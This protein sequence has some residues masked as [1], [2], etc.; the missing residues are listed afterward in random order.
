MKQRQILN[1]E[2]AQACLRQ[3]DAQVESYTSLY[4][5]NP[6]LATLVSY[7]T[8]RNMLIAAKENPEQVLNP[9]WI[10]ENGLSILDSLV[11]IPPSNWR[12]VGN[13]PA[14]KWTKVAN[15][16]GSKKVNLHKQRLLNPKYL[17]ELHQLMQAEESF[18]S[19]Y[20]QTFA[21][22]GV[23]YRTA[24][25]YYIIYTAN[26]EQ[27][28]PNWALE[29]GRSTEEAWLLPPENIVYK[30]TWPFG[31]WIN[32]SEMDLTE[33]E[34]QYLQ[35]KKRKRAKTPKPYVS[36]RQRLFNPHLLKRILE[37]LENGY[38][39]TDVYESTTALHGQ[40]SYSSLWRLIKQDYE[41]NPDAVMPSWAL[42]MQDVDQEQVWL[43]IPKHIAWK[44]RW[45]QGEWVTKGAIAE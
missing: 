3:L 28:C 41:Q 30:G 11:L 2:F 9:S 39:L 42:S 36:R 29:Q 13:F 24:Q 37:Q 7:G 20:A 4:R 16:E 23:S 26:P 33:E 19:A 22:K 10:G 25:K 38:T 1:P 34:R 18:N 45:P 44:G 14:G 40:I 6:E 31:Q 8:F 27:A 5:N 17:Q 43:I 21:A 35:N 32:L 12:W 15:N